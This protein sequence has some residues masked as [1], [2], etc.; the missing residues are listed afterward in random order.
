MAETWLDQQGDPEDP[1]VPQVDAVSDPYA[2]V[3]SRDVTA[4]DS[5][6][7]KLDQLSPPPDS[8]MTTAGPCLPRAGAS[9]Q[10]SRRIDLPVNE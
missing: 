4:T 5:R 10:L 7:R 6:G 8:P 9:E 2:V 1:V 3:D